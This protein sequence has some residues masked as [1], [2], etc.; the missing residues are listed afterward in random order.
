VTS[1]Q[2]GA[3]PLS[4]FN[5]HVADTNDP[6]D[7]VDLIQNQLVPPGA[8]LYFARNTAPVGY[9]ICNGSIVSRTTYSSLFSAIGTTFGAGN[10]TT[11][12]GVPDLR[13]EFIRC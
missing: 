1:V 7:T 11:T 12:F 13:G 5:A 2:I 8:I 3:T 4:T 10:G 6:H 9:L